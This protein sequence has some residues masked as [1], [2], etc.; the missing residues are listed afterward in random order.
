MLLGCKIDC[1]KGNGQT[2]INAL[3]VKY[4]CW[5]DKKRIKLLKQMSLIWTMQQI[6][7]FKKKWNKSFIIS[8]KK[9]T[10][11]ASQNMGLQHLEG[12]CWRR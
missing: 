10:T 6:T 4:L 9:S 3:M 5:W 1:H 12:Q 7:I 2:G 8:M 11:Q